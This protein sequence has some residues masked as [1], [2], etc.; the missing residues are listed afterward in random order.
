MSPAAEKRLLQI[1]VACALP[2]SVV[3]ALRSIAIGPGWIGDAGPV[4]TDLDSHFRYLS[5]IF[6]AMLAGYASCISGIERKGARLRLMAAL[7]VAGGLA[8]GWSL[9]DAGVPSIGH[10]VGLGLELIVVP[11]IVIW[12]ARVARRFT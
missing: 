11:L 8:R 5:G 2:L 9:I 6:L 3:V 1:A 7:T 10:R 12:Q 4:P